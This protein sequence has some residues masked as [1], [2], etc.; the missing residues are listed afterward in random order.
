MDTLRKPESEAKYQEDIAQGRTG[1]LWS[2][3]AIYETPDYKIIKNNY[4]YDR[5]W[6]EHV[7]LIT[8]APIDQAFRWAREYAEENGY[9]QVLYN[10]SFK[11]SVKDINHIHILKL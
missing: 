9:S 1:S 8:L 10:T 6:Q 7:L 2:E 3:P 5:M 4:P 11:Q